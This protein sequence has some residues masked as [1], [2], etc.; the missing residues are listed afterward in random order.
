[1]TIAVLADEGLKKEWLKKGVPETVELLWC[2]TV[3]TLVATVAEVYVDLLYTPDNERTK[4]LTMRSGYPFFIN[5]VEYTTQQTG[6][7]FIRINAWPGFLQRDIIEIAFA[8][9][10]QEAIVQR[11]FNQLGW[12]YQL[13]PDTPGM[14]TARII[15]SIINEAYYTYGEKISTKDEID[16]AM[17]LGTSYPYGPFEWSELIGLEKIGSLLM[18]LSKSDSRYNLAPTLEKEIVQMQSR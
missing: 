8:D 17:R 13:V 1:M 10:S 3:K 5:A 18:E 12:R 7:G 4:Q 2:G 15:A 14:I 9:S 11:V 6:A 16:I